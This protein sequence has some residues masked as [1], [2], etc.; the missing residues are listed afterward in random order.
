MEL[1][2]A[3]GAV[4][5][6]MKIDGLYPRTSYYTS[7]NDIIYYAG[8]KVGGP[9]EVIGKLNIAT[10]T[11]IWTKKTV[12]TQPCI[13]WGSVMLKDDSLVAA[14][15]SN[16]EIALVNFGIEDGSLTWE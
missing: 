14:L 10:Q 12:S 5:R 4:T 9:Y 11:F 6:S 3:T 8:D 16:Q 1:D 13:S 15:D 2:A 7:D